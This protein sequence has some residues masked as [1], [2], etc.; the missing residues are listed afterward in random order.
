MQYYNL[1]CHNP[2]HYDRNFDSILVRKVNY[3]S[4]LH[5]IHRMMVDTEVRVSDMCTYL[6]YS[7]FYSTSYT[8]I[9]QHVVDTM[10][11]IQPLLLSETY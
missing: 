7:V 2:I 5:H 3:N 9:V 6:C 8:G 10:E 11:R 4:P 1:L